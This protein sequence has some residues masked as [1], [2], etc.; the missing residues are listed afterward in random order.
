ME[1]A[2]KSKPNGCA[3]GKQAKH[4]IQEPVPGSGPGAVPVPAL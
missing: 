4:E 3:Q 2:G 1:V